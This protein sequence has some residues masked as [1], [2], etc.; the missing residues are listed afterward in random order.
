MEKTLAGMEEKV[1]ELSLRCENL[2][3]EKE[4]LC[5]QMNEEKEQCKKEMNSLQQQLDAIK[6]RYIE[7]TAEWEKI[8]AEVGFVFF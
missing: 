5:A 2:V 6:E 3:V 4:S 8:L 1:T 7:E